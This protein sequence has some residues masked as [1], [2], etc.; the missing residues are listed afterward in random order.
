MLLQI[1]VCNILKKVTQ[2]VDETLRFLNL[3]K[4]YTLYLIKTKDVDIVDRDI[5]K[6]FASKAQLG[7]GQHD[8]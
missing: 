7:S 1:N 5:D 3:V 4:N 6:D 2:N 8:M